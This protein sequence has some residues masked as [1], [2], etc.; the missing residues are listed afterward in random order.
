MGQSSLFVVEAAVLLV[1][2]VAYATVGYVDSDDAI[3]TQTTKEGTEQHNDVYYGEDKK[4]DAAAAAIIS[5]TTSSRDP[6]IP[7]CNLYMAESTIPGAGIGIFTTQP[8]HKGQP[9]GNG[10]VYIP[11]LDLEW[12][13][14]ASVA[15]AAAQ[16]E[17]AT[18]K[19]VGED[20]DELQPPQ[21]QQ[22]QHFGFVDPFGDYSW[23]G[24]VMGCSHEAYSYEYIHMFAPG[25]DAAVNSHSA[26]NNVDKSTPM[27][28][29]EIEERN[30][31]QLHRSIHAGVG[32]FTP[33]HN[34]T[35]HA[36]HYIPP[37]GELFKAYGDEWY[38]LTCAEILREPSCQI[39]LVVSVANEL[40]LGAVDLLKNPSC[41]Q[42]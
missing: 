21:S 42:Q 38:V 27:V 31:V 1:V 15:A 22:Q 30:F 24:S 34:G 10:D 4:D 39:S 13:Y 3:T 11:I 26:L 2:L 37:G 35:T 41:Q 5:N 25:I 32:T 40:F 28:R 8:I 19:Q 20:G 23:E 16:A 7:K 9:I 33:Y 18:T 6:Q 36:L 14:E 17:H 12:H 29:A